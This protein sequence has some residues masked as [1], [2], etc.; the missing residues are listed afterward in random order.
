MWSFILNVQ[1]EAQAHGNK[2]DE[3][4]DFGISGA[5]CFC[6]GLLEHQIVLVVWS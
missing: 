2:A 3:V 1:E 5:S 6:L 4:E